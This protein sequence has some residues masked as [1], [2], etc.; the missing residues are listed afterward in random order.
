MVKPMPSVVAFWVACALACSSI[1]TPAAAQVADARQEQARELFEEGLALA[2]ADRWAE[3]LS[4]FRQSEALVPRPS[5]SYNIAN[6]LYRLDRPV[7]ALAQLDEYDRM[8][9]VRTDEDAQKRS[10]SLRELLEGAVGHVGLRI[11]PDTAMVFIDGR[12]SLLVGAERDLS[13]NPGMHSL[14]VTNEGYEPYLGEIRVERGSRQALSVELKPLLSEPAPSP[15]SIGSAGGAAM[16]IETSPA[17]PRGPAPDDRKPFVKRPGFWVMIGVI[18]AAGIGAGVAVA[19]IRKDDSPSCGTTGNC[20]T[21]QG[22][23]VTSF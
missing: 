1:P 9:A 20:A 13:L 19:V 5:T 3:A 18:A 7:E 15:L 17:A 2:K 4:A 6:A 14:R 23:T 11:Y 12:P 8:A 10:E 16:S 22:L 21:T